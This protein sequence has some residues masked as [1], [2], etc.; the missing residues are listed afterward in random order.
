ML[1]RS[2]H[3]HSDALAPSS[4]GEHRVRGGGNALMLAAPM[5]SIMEDGVLFLPGYIALRW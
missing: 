3:E 1:S 5:F 4:L 2:I